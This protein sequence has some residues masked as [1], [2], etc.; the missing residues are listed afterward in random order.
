MR[1]NK[2]KSAASARQQ[3]NEDSTFIAQSCISHPAG[4]AAKK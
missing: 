2:K 1:Q 3:A 4:K